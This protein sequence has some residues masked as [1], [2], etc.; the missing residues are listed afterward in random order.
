MT[1]FNVSQ[2]G[3]VLQAD[4]LQRRAVAALQSPQP[5]HG[6]PRR[7]LIQVGQRRAVVRRLRPRLRPARHIRLGRQRR[8]GGRGF[9]S[10]RPSPAFRPP[11]LRARR[12][13][14]R[15]LDDAAVQ[16]LEGAHP[17]RQEVPALERGGQV[18]RAARLQHVDG[19]DEGGHAQQ[20]GGHAHQ[21]APAGQRQPQ[22][23]GGQ[24]QE[25][26]QQVEHGEPAVLGGALAQRAGH[27]DGQPGGRDGVPQQD[28]Q[29]V[30]EQ[31]AQG[32]LERQ[33]TGSR[34]F[35]G[36]VPHPQ[37]GGASAVT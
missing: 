14:R 24:Q 27:A 12:A 7:R 21:G 36:L 33:D 8:R 30:E 2:G 20:G 6:D 3:G 13:A 9:H 32:D 16:R 29:D 15:R 4:P 23:Q 28:A 19:G 5:E 34:C 37:L 18:A 11:P 17:R 22:H 35:K 1:V 31:V 25:G 26:Q 10:S